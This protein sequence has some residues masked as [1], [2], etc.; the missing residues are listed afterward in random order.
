MLA[1]LG[2]GL[3]AASGCASAKSFLDEK[4]PPPGFE[5][6]AARTPSVAAQPPAP[7]T[8][9]PPA[10]LPAGAQVLA[11]EAQTPAAEVP[12]AAPPTGIDDFV[13]L[14]TERDPR[15]VRATLAIE[16]ARG[17]H[18]QA[19]LYPNPEVAINW[20]ELGDRS[21]P[22][23]LGVLAAPIVTQTIV[24]AKKL[25]LSQAVAAREVDQATLV[26]LGERYAV[27]AGVRAAFYEALALQRRVADL[28]E[29]LKLADDAVATGKTLLDNKKIAR[30]DL[31]QIELERARVQADANAAA[32]QLPAAYR[33]L[34]AAAGANGLPVG[35]LFGSLD[36]PPSY[37][38]EQAQAAAVASH[39][40]VR[41]AVVGVERARAA[42]LR[43]EA[44]AVPNVSVYTGFIRQFENRSYDGAVGVSMRVPVFDRNQGNIRAARAELGMASQNVARAENEV[45]GRVAAAYQRYAAARARA[46]QYRNEILPRVQETYELS[47]NAF[48]NGQ[49][50]Y[51]KVIDAQ[52]G[53]NEARLGLNT[54][55]AEAWAAAAELSG[56]LLE[57]NWPSAGTKPAEPPQ[58]PEEPKR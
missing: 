18:L 23:R 3:A 6:T 38:L 7:G 39:P 43:A 19:G 40:D 36:D 22:D 34:A 50:D 54:A 14:A 15:L 27:A 16:A 17:R 28:T 10:I 9:R 25:T 33:R 12:A 55:L 37:D 48:R 51:L 11:A 29:L 53:V 45:A 47:L 57:E 56:L 52:R 1:A 5:S 44:E 24:T 13:R 2:G 35:K 20:D 46:A 31:T 4:L 30:L 32:Q 41:S 58:P 21:S 26:S 8:P 49:Y 42:V